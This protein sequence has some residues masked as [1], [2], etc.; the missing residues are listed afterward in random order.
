MVQVSNCS[1]E[2]TTCL[3]GPYSRR[4]MKELRA[5]EKAEKKYS[6]QDGIVFDDCYLHLH[7]FK[8]EPTI[9]EFISLSLHFLNACVRKGQLKR[10]SPLGPKLYPFSTLTFKSSEEKERQRDRQFLDPPMDEPST[11]L[12]WSVECKWTSL[13]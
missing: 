12:F 8:N 9:Q 7:Q 5:R 10:F 1:K 13:D 6:T 2:H 3:K 11:D 4:S